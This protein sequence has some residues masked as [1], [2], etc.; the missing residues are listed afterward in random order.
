[1]ERASVRARHRALLAARDSTERLEFFSDAVFAIAMTL[2]VLDLRVPSLATVPR[3]ELG[4]ALLD[5]APKLFAY[6][7]SFAVIG[8]N[9]SSHFRRFQVIDRVDRR[10]V[11]LDLLLLLLVAFVPFP[12]AVLSEYG[13]EILSVVLYAATVALINGVQCLIWV[14][15]RRAGLLSPLV[16]RGLYRYVRRNILVPGVVFT[17]SIG[18]ALLGQPL[19]AMLSWLAISPASIALSRARIVRSDEYEPAVR[20]RSPAGVTAVPGTPAGPAPPGTPAA[21]GP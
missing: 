20:P 4:R 2:L 5:Q 11:Q 7:L 14:H 10:L 6:V 19:I 13:P 17:V 16:D 15:V 3:D 21:P 8:L 12:T 18:I 9:W 1:M